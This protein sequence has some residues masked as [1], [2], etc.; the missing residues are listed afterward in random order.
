MEPDVPRA[1][2]TT[3]TVAPLC[4]PDTTQLVADNF[5]HLPTDALVTTSAT[6]PSE[7]EV[8]HD[9]VMLP[10][11]VDFT[12]GFT[13]SRPGVIFPDLLTRNSPNPLE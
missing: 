1:E 6:L 11:L 4:N 5:L 13:T 12:T 2:T 8:F 3:I 7:S 10:F 9:T